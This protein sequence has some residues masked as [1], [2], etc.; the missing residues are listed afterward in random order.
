MNK[1]DAGMASLLRVLIWLYRMLLS[2]VLGPRCR[3]EPSCS[4]YAMEAVKR[5]GAGRGSLLALW[6]IG[7]CHPW[8]G[9]GYD[10]VPDLPRRSGAGRP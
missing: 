5:Y 3:F 6:R 9:C 4:A 2:P 10:P 8:G 1:I 7:R